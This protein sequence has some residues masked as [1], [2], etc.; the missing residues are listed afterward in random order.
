[1]LAW[2]DPVSLAGQGLLGTGH[3]SKALSI[4]YQ[5]HFVILSLMGL[6][7]DSKMMKNIHLGR[8]DFICLHFQ[9]L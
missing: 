9:S 2:S 6:E 4:I 7:K 1:M 8:M 3:F 5:M